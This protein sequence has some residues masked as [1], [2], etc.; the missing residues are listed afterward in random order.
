MPMPMPIIVASE[1]D[2]SGASTNAMSRPVSMLLTARPATATTIGSPA[3]TTEP[4]VSSRMMAAA[5]RP[6][7]SEPIGALLGL[8]DRLAAERDRQAVRG[9]GVGDVEHLL[10]V[11]DRHV[12]RVHHVEAATCATRVRPSGEMPP[13]VA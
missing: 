9:R 3:A 12:R 11:L 4:K 6:M 8:L 1:V 13:G 2:Q 5:A 10:A 7:P